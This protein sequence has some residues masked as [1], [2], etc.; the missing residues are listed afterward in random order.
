MDG[1]ISASSEHALRSSLLR[2][3]LELRRRRPR[4]GHPPCGTDNRYAGVGSFQ[5]EKK[6]ISSNLRRECARLLLINYYFVIKP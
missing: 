2:W 6:C 3:E 1:S 4:R 5:G